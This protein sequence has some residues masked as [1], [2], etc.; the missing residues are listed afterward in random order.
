MK[1]GFG[2]NLPAAW[3]SGLADFCLAVQQKLEPECVILVGSAADGTYCEG[4]DL[5]LLV[6]GSALPADFFSRLE[7]LARLRPPG[8]PLEVM[9]YTPDEFRRMLREGHVTAL[10]AYH[11]GVPLLGE[12]WFEQER[13]EFLALKS[14]GLRRVR[15]A[16]L[17]PPD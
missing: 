3:R 6:I 1:D 9:G 5:D 14:R 12:A 11:K 4:S 7:V 17:L 8:V 10:E 13:E 16:W 2:P 15:G